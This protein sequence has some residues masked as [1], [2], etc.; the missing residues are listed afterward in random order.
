MGLLP[1]H[2]P[3]WERKWSRN[4]AAWARGC[5]RNHF[6]WERRPHD[7]HKRAPVIETQEVAQEVYRAAVVR[8]RWWWWPGGD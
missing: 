3:E 6:P 5:C 2:C 4:E 1:Y 8:S 7:A